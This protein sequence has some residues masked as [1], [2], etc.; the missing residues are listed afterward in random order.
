VAAQA[1]IAIENARL[2]EQQKRITAIV[3][4]SNDAI[5]SKDLTG[6]ITSWNPAATRILGYSPEEMVGQSVLRLI[7]EELHHEEPVILGKI[8]SGERIEHFETVRVRKDGQRID[9]SLT[10][11]PLHD[12]SG[13]I[14]GASKILR[15]ISA[16]KRAEASL[17]QAEKM[18]AAGRMAATIAHEVN[19]PLES[20][21]NLIYLAK[22]NADDSGQVRTYLTTAESEVAR[23][24]HLAK[25]TLGF[26]R[27]HGSPVQAAITDLVKEAVVVYQR[28]CQEAGITVDLKFHSNRILTVRKGEMMQVISNLIANAI[29][30]MP[31]GGVLSIA[32]EDTEVR[33]VSG[34]SLT[35]TDTGVG[36]PQENL[37]RIFEAFF[38]TRTSI[39]T[40]IGL[41][42]VKQ[43]V[44]GHGGT[45]QVESCT[46]G[47]AQ[48]TRMQTFLPLTNA[49]ATDASTG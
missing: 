10:I 1:A 49:P 30:A 37:S 43:F 40:G 25:Q 33:N 13:K 17:L 34:V 3:A 6:T 21:M 11:S 19:N 45:I 22:A 28:K 42:V 44:E 48:G 39:G 35:V 5:L 29:Y 38:T 20:V 32:T 2:R 15:D 26:Y 41:F 16:N 8:G 27:E 4:T 46:D 18:A 23:V 12:A 31:T 36:I 47:A 14:I 7:P 24:S 9:V